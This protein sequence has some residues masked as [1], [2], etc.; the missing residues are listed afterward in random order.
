MYYD[1]YIIVLNVE[2]TTVIML[3][4]LYIYSESNINSNFVLNVF[5]D[6]AMALT[7][8]GISIYK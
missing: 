4:L 6:I 3:Q 8:T 5:R 7:H 1:C 2:E